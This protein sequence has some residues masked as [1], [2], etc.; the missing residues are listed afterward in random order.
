MREYLSQGDLYFGNEWN[1]S[2]N[3]Q[4]QRNNLIYDK[5]H[6]NMVIGEPLKHLSAFIVK[7][8]IC[9]K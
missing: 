6:F 3:L 2:L 9:V 1:L 4:Q 5:Y 8:H 7:G